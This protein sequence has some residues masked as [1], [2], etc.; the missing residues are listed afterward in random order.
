MPGFFS[1]DAIALSCPGQVPGQRRRRWPS[2][3]P[4]TPSDCWSTGLPIDHVVT[5]YVG[6]TQRS[7]ILVASVCEAITGRSADKTSALVRATRGDIGPPWSQRLLSAGRSRY[8]VWRLPHSMTRSANHYY[9][10]VNCGTT[11]FPQ[12]CTDTLSDH[13]AGWKTRVKDLVRRNRYRCKCATTSYR[14]QTYY[15]RS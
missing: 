4:E 10:S 15:R 9:T 1:L 12:Y 6:P 5:F 3:C 2:T 11:D 13:Y 14:D 8:R 7:H